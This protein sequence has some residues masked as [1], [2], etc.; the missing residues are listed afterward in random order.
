[1]ATT[2]TPEET[3]YIRRLLDAMFE[4]YNTPRQEIMGVTS[5]QALKAARAPSRERQS[6]NATTVAGETYVA[7]DKGLTNSQAEKLLASLKKSQ[8][9]E[10]SREGWYT[11][12][13]RALV[14]LRNWLVTTYND[15][16]AEEGDWQRIKF[17]VACKEI[18]TT[19]QRCSNLDCNVRLHDVCEKSYWKTR[20]QKKCVK[21]ET[22]W[23]CKYWVGE[24]AITTTAA[25]NEGRR[26]SKGKQR[27]S[28]VVVEEE[29]DDDEEASLPEHGSD[30]EA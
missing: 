1:M 16:D 8:W 28:E 12:A 25:Y 9:L 20:R 3:A 13:P 18:V 24:R 27:R 10:R 11:L 7:I 4:K 22:E 14:E 23:D 21:C 26:I 6:L 5:M 2:N 17:C 15:P 29:D 19:G 30:G